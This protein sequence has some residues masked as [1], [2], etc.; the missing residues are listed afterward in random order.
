MKRLVMLMALVAFGFSARAQEGPVISSAVIAMDRNNDLAAAKK[1]IDEAGSIISTKPEAEISYKDMRKYLFYAGKINLAIAESEKAEVRALDAEALAKAE[2]YLMETVAYE[3]KLG[4]EKYSDDAKT[5]LP[6]VA[7]LYNNIG[8][9]NYQAQAYEPAYAAFMKTYNLRMLNNQTDSSTLYNAALMA[10]NAKMYQKSIEL[11][12]RLLE[13]G[14]KGYVY[15]AKNMAN[16]QVAEFPSKKMMDEFVEYRGYGEP[17]VE[18]NDLRPQ[19]YISIA[20]MSLE[21]GDTASFMEYVKKGR[22]KYPENAALLT[23]ELDIYLKSKE[24]DKALVNL[25]QA[26][27]QDPNDPKAKIYY[28]NKGIILQTEMN[29]PDEA[30]LAY[31]KAVALDS[32]YADALYMN[33]LVYYDKAKGVTEEMNGLPFNA[34]KKYNALKAKQQEHFKQALPYFEQARKATPNDRNTLMALWEI[35]R[36]LKMTDQAIAT[37]QEIDAL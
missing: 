24:Y 30:V 35:Y 18:K 31:Q 19:F 8:L 14:Y 9:D 5:L 32:L 12:K 2:K 34:T 1:Y 13:L 15:R 4:K 27:A 33:G 22:E 25:D 28:Y 21:T 20:A 23:T 6:T 11:N 36:V 26:I 37:K 10:Q 16:G 3:E 29:K 17:Q 7:T